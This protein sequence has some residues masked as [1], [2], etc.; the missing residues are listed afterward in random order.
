[1]K[2]RRG[3]SPSPP[4][5]RAAVA[6]RSSWVQSR[7]YRLSNH[8]TSIMDWSSGQITDAASKALSSIDTSGFY[9]SS[10]SAANDALNLGDAQ[11]FE[12]SISPGTV[13]AQL[14]GKDPSNPSTALELLKGMKWLLANM[15]KGRDVSDFFPHVVKLVGTS[16]LEVRKM[17]YIY[18]ARYANHD[19][20]CRELALLSI[21][22]FQRGLAD[23]EPLLRSLA[24][25]VL[26]CM[27]VPDVLQLQILG[28]RTCCKDTSPYVRKCAA[29]AVGKLHP[30]CMEIAD[31]AQA[32]QLVDIITS[33]LEDDGSTM[34]LTSAMIAF[35]E[36]CP[37]RLDLLH[38][39]F[40]K[41][42]HLL[43]DMDEWGQ[44]VVLDL[45]MRYCRTYFKQPYGQVSGSAEM[46]DQERRV[47]RGAAE[48]R[49]ENGHA[50]SEASDALISL[51][52]TTASTN[53]TETPA[54]TPRQ[55]QK[56]KRRVV[57]KAFY[58]DDEDSSS[59]EEVDPMFP[60]SGN[61][62]GAL[63]E[64]P[65]LGSP[66][67]GPGFR[68]DV[69]D[70]TS[71]EAFGILRS[72]DIDF[73]EDGDLDEDHKLLLQSSLPLLRSRNS[74]VVLA[75][76]SLHYHCGIASIKV[77]VFEY[78]LS[79]TLLGKRLLNHIKRYARRSGR[80]W[81]VYTVIAEKYSM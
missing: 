30:R 42:C 33:L 48:V 73:D 68:D 36:I 55:K 1:M 79:R 53:G 12:E 66:Q 81:F 16:N 32:N 18:L 62:A 64:Q 11:F 15:S 61:I 56:V 52:G 37:E 19:D 27:E 58:S 24:L 25:R 77:S 41:T 44:V 2:G 54:T 65:L 74:A 72:N 70:A 78:S 14:Q 34:V 46:I 17:V 57:R 8:S 3:L 49:C 47:I 75:T 39:C 38:V 26:T 51:T 59:T 40:R 50:T 69:N 7:D 43:T 21:N 4:G 80:L 6:R 71:N 28:V 13:R 35:S 63:R 23:R 5:S 22:A 31:D 20:Q 76:C 45:L 10:I 60:S 29:N 67:A 9:S